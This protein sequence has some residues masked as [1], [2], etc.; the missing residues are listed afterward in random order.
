MDSMLVIGVVLLAISFLALGIHPTTRPWALRFWWAFL[1]VGVG[2][3]GALLGRRGDEWGEDA[4][5][6][7]VDLKAA[8]LENKARIEA[9][10]QRARLRSQS[11]LEAFDAERAEIEAMGTA[12]ERL[13]RWAKLGRGM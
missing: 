3:V 13:D 10:Q 7:I 4:D 11:E 12:S 8:T 1:A 9:E 2:I 6:T 5:S